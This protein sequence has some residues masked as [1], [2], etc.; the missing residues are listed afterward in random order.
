MLIFHQITKD[1]WGKCPF[2]QTSDIKWIK[3]TLKYCILTLI[4]S[5]KQKR[6]NIQCKNLKDGVT[7]IGSSFMR[8]RPTYPF[9]CLNALYRA[10]LMCQCGFRY[11]KRRGREG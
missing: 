5:L 4:S 2:N 6:S 9:V 3:T 7:F 8:K 1:F 11:S 10:S